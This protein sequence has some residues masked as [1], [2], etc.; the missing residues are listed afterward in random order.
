MDC[1]S[2]SMG[3]DSFPQQILRDHRKVPGLNRRRPQRPQRPLVRLEEGQAPV[4]QVMLLAQ[5][6]NDGGNLPQMAPRQP[7][8]EMVLE[9]EL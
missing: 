8:E 1:C 6:L 5:L 3:V 2:S 7:R 4:G 9:L